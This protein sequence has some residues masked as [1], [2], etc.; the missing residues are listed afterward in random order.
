MKTR[1]PLKF[2]LV[3][4]LPAL[5]LAWL[6]MAL[7]SCTPS[8]VAANVP[9]FNTEFYRNPVNLDL[10]GWTPGEALDDFR[11]RTAQEAH[12]DTPSQERQ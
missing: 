2:P 4:L 9:Q 8:K 5:G 6:G 1:C 7:I 12:R 11:L 3:I 10:A